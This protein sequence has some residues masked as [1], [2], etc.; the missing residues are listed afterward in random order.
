MAKIYLLRHGMPEFPNGIHCCL[1]HTDLPLSYEG[2]VQAEQ[3]RDYFQKNQL[4]IFSSHLSRSKQTAEI[5]ANGYPIT[6]LEDLC[7]LDA[8]LWDGLSFVEIRE[9]FPE[10]YEERGKNPSLPPLG[11]E[12]L[13]EGINRFYK[14]MRQIKEDAIVV[15]HCS[16]NRGVLYKSLGLSQQQQWEIPQPYGCINIIEFD[17]V[18]IQPFAVGVMPTEAPN[19]KQCYNLQRKYKVQSHVIA[20]C[21]AVNRCTSWLVDKLENQ[22]Y[23]LNKEVLQAAAILH[24][25]FRFEANHPVVAAKCLRQEGYGKVAEIIEKHHQ[26]EKDDFNTINE[27]LVLFLADKLVLEDKFV[28]LKERFEMSRKKCISS[29][30]QEAWKRQYNQAIDAYEKIKLSGVCIEELY[31]GN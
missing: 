12:T 10:Y 27:T 17:G 6:I 11:G 24:D 23:R 28:T 2:I 5:V 20:H 22:G 7:E 19:L 15:S 1:G 26:L 9:K 16:L 4:P 25:L 21:E 30:A 31:E 3:L 29:C 18:H 14:A 13:E 8:G